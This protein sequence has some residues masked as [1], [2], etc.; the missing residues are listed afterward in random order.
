MVVK[1][2]GGRGL[3]DTVQLLYMLRLELAGAV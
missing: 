1:R 3:G 2:N